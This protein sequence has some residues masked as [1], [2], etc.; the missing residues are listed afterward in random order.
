MQSV[1]Q[2]VPAPAGREGLFVAIGETERS[3]A[4]ASLRLRGAAATEVH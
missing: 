4:R 2:C 1:L 3:A